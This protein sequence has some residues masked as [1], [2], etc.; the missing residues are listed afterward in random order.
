MGRHIVGGGFGLDRKIFGVAAVVKQILQAD[1]FPR[2]ILDED[3]AVAGLLADLL[4]FR[5]APL[6]GERAADVVVKHLYFS[7]RSSPFLLLR[8]L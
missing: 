7:H 4:V 6:D 1:D 2:L 5:V 3:N 8:T